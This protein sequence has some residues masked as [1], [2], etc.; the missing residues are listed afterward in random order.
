MGVLETQMGVL[1]TQMV[2]WSG[3]QSPMRAQG[4]REEAVLIWQ[5]VAKSATVWL[6]EID[7]EG[8]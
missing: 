5:M 1:E 2:M 8:L 7:P 6:P 3:K 4:A